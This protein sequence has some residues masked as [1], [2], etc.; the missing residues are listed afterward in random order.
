AGDGPDFSVLDQGVGGAETAGGGDQATR[1]AVGA[2]RRSRGARSEDRAVIAGEAGGADADILRA[3]VGGVVIAEHA[4]VGAAAGA[5]DDGGSSGDGE[6]GERAA[7]VAGERP[8][9]AGK[10]IGIGIGG[11]GGGILKGDGEGGAGEV[12]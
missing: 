7:G 6:G 9:D 11:G 4:D 8:E 3:E 10:K 12:D 2:V 1:G 5:S